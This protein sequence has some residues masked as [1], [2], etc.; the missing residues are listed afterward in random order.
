[1]TATATTTRTSRQ[2]KQQQA[3]QQQPR[4]QERHARS[5]NNRDGSNSRDVTPVTATAGMPRHEQ[6]DVNDNK[7][8]EATAR[9]LPTEGTRQKHGRLTAAIN[10]QQQ[11][12]RSIAEIART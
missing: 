6:E 2:E 1:M 4:Q 5:S 7:S 8:S 9:T 10:Q 3:Q 11:V 12:D